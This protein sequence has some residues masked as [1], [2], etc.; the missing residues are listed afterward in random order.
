MDR[1]P[2]PSADTLPASEREVLDLIERRRGK[3]PAPFVPLL[4]S[5]VA[6]DLFEQL[7]TYLWSSLPIAVLETVF[8]MTARHCRCTHQ[9]DTHV[10]KAR[11]AGLTETDISTL[12]QGLPL[13]DGVL[14]DVSRFVGMFHHD[15]RVSQALFDAVRSALSDRGVVDLVMFCGSAHTVAMLLNLRQSPAAADDG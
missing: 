8:L 14:G 7:S 1:Y 2:F 15:Q 9:W 13:P 11:A 10:P 5:P 4:K 6:A 12:A 3:L